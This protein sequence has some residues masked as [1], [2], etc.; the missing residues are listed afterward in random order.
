MQVR[1]VTLFQTQKE[2]E[3]DPKEAIG[4][5]SRLCQRL[6][7]HI[8]RKGWGVQTRRLATPPWPGWTAPDK[9]EMLAPQLEAKALSQ[10]SQFI[11]LGPVG[12]NDPSDALEAALKTLKASQVSFFSTKI[13]Q[14]QGLARGLID[15]SAQAMIDI[16]HSTPSGYGNLRFAALANCKPG[17]PFFPT[18]FS[19]PEWERPRVA[20]GLEWCDLALEAFN[21]SSSENIEN[22]AR[23]LRDLLTSNMWKLERNVKEGCELLGLDYGGLDLSLTP[24]IGKEFTAGAA[25]EAIGCTL[26][27]PGGVGAVALITGVLKHLPVQ[28]CGYSGVMLPLLEDPLL[29]R[30]ANEGLLTLK[31]LLLMATVCGCGL[32]TVPL[33]GDTSAPEIAA[34]LS[35]LANLSVRLDKPL[36]ARL[37]VVPRKTAGELTQFDSPY[38]HNGPVLSL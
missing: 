38:L 28:R 11:S 29:V 10:G 20:L 8:I 12:P 26:G 32:D 1:T 24:A 9:L 7:S 37:F 23:R 17:T 5:G 14:D 16:G 18:A 36:S 13:T 31:D 22:S 30:R 3:R 15:A 6:A 33:P 25:L 27:K 34:L 4:Q 2:L 21:K 19:D 35:D